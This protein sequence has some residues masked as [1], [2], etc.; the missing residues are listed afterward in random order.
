MKE[1][2]Y[3]KVT[4]EEEAKY[5]KYNDSQRQYQYISKVI[6]RNPNTPTTKLLKTLNEKFGFCVLTEKVVIGVQNKQLDWLEERQN[7][8]PP[9]W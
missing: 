4:P 3:A 6:K 5:S 7:E 2:L 1:Y 8:M 9:M